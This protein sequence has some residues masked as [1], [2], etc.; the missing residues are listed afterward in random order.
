MTIER[1]SRMLSAAS[2]AFVIG[3]PWGGEFRLSRVAAMIYAN[4]RAQIMSLERPPGE[5]ILESHIAAA[6]G[7]SRTP[8]REAT[9]V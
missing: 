9:E 8:V 4:L 3:K 1:M 5:P 7:V 6:S 2:R